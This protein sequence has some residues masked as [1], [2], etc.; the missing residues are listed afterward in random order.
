MSLFPK[1][2]APNEADLAD[3]RGL[4]T[5]M[6][7]QRR[8]RERRLFGVRVF[9]GRDDEQAQQSLLLQRL[10][11]EPGPGLSGQQILQESNLNMRDVRRFMSTLSDDDDDDDNASLRLISRRRR[12][13]NHDPLGRNTETSEHFQPLHYLHL[14]AP[15]QLH[16]IIYA[17]GL[18]AEAEVDREV[19][20]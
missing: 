16:P 20:P 6:L 15:T 3:T 18:E 2:E 11:S 4:L 7:E 1:D 17:I 13:T 8:E 14:A 12:A 5:F 10:P 19:Q 9:P